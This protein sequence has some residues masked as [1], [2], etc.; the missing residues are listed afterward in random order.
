MK[1]AWVIMPQE[2]ARQD[3]KYRLRRVLR[4]NR[5]TL[6]STLKYHAIPR[7]AAAVMAVGS[8]VMFCVGSASLSTSKAMA[9]DQ[10][11]GSRMVLACSTSAP[12]HI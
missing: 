6:T 12:E 4:V 10:C 7:N 9:L 1:T 2:Q 11:E 3:Q 5:R 8:G